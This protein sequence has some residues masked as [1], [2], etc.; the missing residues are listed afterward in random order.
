[1]EEKGNAKENLGFLRPDGVMCFSNCCTNRTE[2]DLSK[3]KRVNELYF[4]HHNKY[5][6]TEYIAKPTGLAC[7]GYG[8]ETFFTTEKPGEVMNIHGYITTPMEMARWRDLHSYGCCRCGGSYDSGEEVSCDERGHG[9]DYSVCKACSQLSDAW[10]RDESGHKWCS[11]ACKY[12]GEA[13]IKEHGNIHGDWPH[14]LEDPDKLGISSDYPVHLPD[15]EK[16]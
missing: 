11:D 15:T 3:Q 12:V 8:D 6:R 4:D 2:E 9:C 14:D 1:M 13:R 7:V 10:K 5:I 16:S